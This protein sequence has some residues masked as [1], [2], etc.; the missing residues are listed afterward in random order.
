MVSKQR[1]AQVRQQPHGRPARPGLDVLQRHVVAIPVELPADGLLADGHVAVDQRVDVP[2]MELGADRVG[3]RR[4][5]VAGHLAAVA[6]RLVSA[7]EQPADDLGIRLGVGEGRDVIEPRGKRLAAQLR[8]AKLDHQPHQRGDRRRVG[9]A[10]ERDHEP[11]GA[12]LA[13][14]VEQGQRHGAGELLLLYG[15]HCVPR[16]QRRRRTVAARRRQLELTPDDLAAKRAV[17]M[18]RRA[19]CHAQAPRDADVHVAAREHMVGERQPR[20]F[21]N[22]PPGGGDVRAAVE[23]R[24]AGLVAEQV[25]EHVARVER[26]RALEHDAPPHVLLAEREVA[27]RGVEDD[28]DRRRGE[29]G[30]RPVGDPR[31]PADLEADAHRRRR[32]GRFEHQVARP[33][34][35][36]RR[37]RSTATSAAGQGRNHR[38][39]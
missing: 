14:V 30:A 21:G 11:V 16:S 7:H 18:A 1:A 10:A 29:P 6:R 9:P 3:D 38:G 34:R 31:V 26:A 36:R 27:G 5:G 17:R 20:P 35:S 2:R 4:R 25:G 12:A 22:H 37:R 19:G 24:A 39:S 32:A 33:A 15:G 23:D 28:V 8:D 13:Q